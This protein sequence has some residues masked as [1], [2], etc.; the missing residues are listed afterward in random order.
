MRVMRHL[1]MIAAGLAVVASSCAD[2]QA[3]GSIPAVQADPDSSST[4][5]SDPAQFP[6]ILDATLEQQDEGVFSVTV[7]VSSPYDSPERYADAWRV[8]SPDRTV[9]G[10]RELTHDHAGEQPFTRSQRGIQIP[11]DLTQVIIQGRDLAN[12]WG[13]GEI[14]VDVPGR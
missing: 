3:T 9:L 12:G 7:T 11:A 6:D 1:G 13:G 2:D 4:A 5:S 10:I 14:T 8:L